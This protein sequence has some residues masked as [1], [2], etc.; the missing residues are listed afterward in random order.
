MENK[1]KLDFPYSFNKVLIIE[2]VA[3]SKRLLK[4]DFKEIGFFVLT[5]SSGEEALK[6]IGKYKPD[7]ITIGHKPP[8][9][10]ITLLLKSVRSISNGKVVF[11]SSRRDSDILNK[12]DNLYI[13]S[14]VNLPKEQHELKEIVYELLTSV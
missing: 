1:Y 10:P 12:E 2:N 8:D 14:I 11:I 3:Y 7:L 9:M 4:K 5:A 6:K 13:N